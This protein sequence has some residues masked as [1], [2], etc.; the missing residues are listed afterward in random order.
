MEPDVVCKNC[1]EKTSTN[2]SYCTKCGAE[3]Q[4]KEKLPESKT[5]EKEQHVPESDEIQMLRAEMDYLT[6]KLDS[7]DPE[8]RKRT[9]WYE[10]LKKQLDS[11]EIK[12]TEFEEALMQYMD[13]IEFRIPV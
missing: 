4:L 8:N 6:S 1:G 13:W 12:L 2:F 9:H 7:T 3:Q 5:P 11:G 10:N